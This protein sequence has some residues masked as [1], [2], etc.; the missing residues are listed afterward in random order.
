MFFLGIVSV[1]VCLL[2]MVA[3]CV[4]LILQV[5]LHLFCG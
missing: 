4:L 2:A 3:S 1:T 5:I